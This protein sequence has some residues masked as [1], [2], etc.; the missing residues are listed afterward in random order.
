MQIRFDCLIRQLIRYIFFSKVALF[1][2]FF[3]KVRIAL[4]W[5]GGSIGVEMED[6]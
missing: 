2:R 1:V 4:L 3:S 6:K 5:Y